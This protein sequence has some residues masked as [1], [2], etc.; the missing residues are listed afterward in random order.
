MEYL[1]LSSSDQ[2]KLINLV[3]EYIVKGWVPKGGV[4]VTGE[5]ISYYYQAM[6]KI[7]K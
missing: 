3:N 1:I 5:I 6:I 7:T 2:S 4:S